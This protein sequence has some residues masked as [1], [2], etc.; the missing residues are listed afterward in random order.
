MSVFTRIALRYAA[1]ALV[2]KGVLAPET[3]HVLISDPDILQ[4]AEVAVGAGLA[5]ASEGWYILA[6]RFG[7]SK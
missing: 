7:W 3:S 6:R 1:A 5:V 4:V 2:T